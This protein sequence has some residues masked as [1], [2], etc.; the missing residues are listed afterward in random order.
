[1]SK[2]I[3]NTEQLHRYPGIQPFSRDYR[4][5]FFGRSSDIEGLYKYLNVNNLVVLYGKSGLGKSSLLNAGL[6]PTIEEKQQYKTIFIRFGSYNALNPTKLKNIFVQKIREDLPDGQDV[7]LPEWSNKEEEL[8]IWQHL[9]TLEW[10]YKDQEGVLIVL[11]QFEE[12]FTY[13]NGEVDDFGKEFSEVVNNRMPEAF[14]RKLYE[15]VEKDP[16]FLDKY[17]DQV[18]FIDQ[19]APLKLLLGIRSDRLSLLD[20]FSIHLPNILKNTYNLNPLNLEQAKRAIIAPAAKTGSYISPTFTYER[21]FLDNILTYLSKDGTRPVETFLL[22]IICQHIEDKVTGMVGDKTAPP[23]EVKQDDIGNLDSIA[24]SYYVEVIQGKEQ[25]SGLPRFVEYEQLMVRHFIETNLIDP[26]HHNR[27]SLDKTFVEQKGLTDELLAK[28]VNARIIRQEPNTVSGI[29]YELSHD[30]LI[31]PVLQSAQQLGNIEETIEAFYR[32]KVDRALQRFI[33]TYFI[34]PEGQIQQFN[35][36]DFGDVEGPL[37][38]LVEGKIARPIADSRYELYQMFTTPA[39][40]FRAEREVKKLEQERSKRRRITM[41]AIMGFLLA[42]IAIMATVFAFKQTKEADFARMGALEAQKLAII[43]KNKSDSLRT[44]ADE[45]RGRAQTFADEATAQSEVAKQEK[46][47]ADIARQA[48]VKARQLAEKEKELADRAR[49]LAIEQQQLTLAEKNRADTLLIQANKARAEAIAALEEAKKQTDFANVARDLA[50]SRL[51]EIEQKDLEINYQDKYIRAQPFLTRARDVLDR[52]PTAALRIAEHAYRVEQFDSTE[53]LLYRIIGNDSLRFY[54]K[55]LRG[56]Q[57]LIFSIAFSPDGKY[58]ASGDDGGKVIIWEV[59]TGTKLKELEGHKDHIWSIAF[60][61][62]GKELVSGSG[63]G[64]ARLWDVQTGNVV[65]AFVGH[66]NGL[67]KIAISPDGKT[68]ITTSPDNTVRFWDMKSGKSIDV[69]FESTEVHSVCYSPDGNF[70]A[71]GTNNAINISNAKN[72]KRIKTLSGGLDRVEAI[73]F[74][75]DGKQLITGNWGRNNKLESL[76]IIW[77]V[78][79]GKQIRTIND[80]HDSVWNIFFS[81]GG[82]YFIPA[83]GEK[84]IDVWNYPQATKAFTIHTNSNSA[85][86]SMVSPDQQFIVS[87]DGNQVKFWHRELTDLRKEIVDNYKNGVPFAQSLELIEKYLNSNEVMQ[88]TNDEKVE[89]GISVKNKSGK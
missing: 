69:I 63:D 21:H 47:R 17:G 28:L 3:K 46:E 44:L 15:M 80:Y 66:T 11:D 60:T 26:V 30:T 19:P 84:N 65:L 23:L 85:F 79:S 81:P 86:T 1:M 62:D 78:A 68:L 13:P 55:V 73:A 41:V 2:K 35:P 4:D 38:T 29:S 59:A 70:I 32:N 31:D 39:L 45:A 83:T 56:H 58:L 87:D 77:D 6:I 12:V 72:L 67:K 24:R 18:E 88:L 8:S 71:V 37:N 51:A 48:A 10:A 76:I 9:K 20:R 50:E 57:G 42:V 43:E 40:K 89:Y 7:F 16:T 36:T 52:N 64:T 82:D 27:I 34:S 61:P 22:Q 75:P 74:S 54:N 25:S 5:V 14:R 49:A 53:N 33:E